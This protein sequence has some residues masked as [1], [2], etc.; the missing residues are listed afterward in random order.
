MLTRTLALTA[1]IALAG[2]GLPSGTRL[3]NAEEA[4]AEGY[5][6]AELRDLVG[7]I[8]LY[9][10]VV[11]AS[12]LP[13]TTYPADV[14]A[15]VALLAQQGGTVS[16]VPEGSTWDPSVQSLLQF[17]DVLTWL[18]Q[19]KEWVEQMAYAVAV[20]Q[21]AVLAAIQ[22]FRKEAQAAG[23][24][25]SD[26]HQVVSTEDTSDGSTEV[27]VIESSS[28][29]VVYVPT[30]Q[31][32][33]VVQ[34]AYTGWAWGAGFAMAAT[35]VWAYN[36]VNWGSNGGDININ[37]SINT[38]NINTGNINAGNN[39][40][41]NRATQFKAPASAAK[42]PAGGV[43]QPSQGGWG[44]ATGKPKGSG[45]KP[46]QR[47]GGA[48]T[49]PAARPGAAGPSNVGGGNK[50]SAGNPGGGAG[51]RPPTAK[52]AAGKPPARPSASP[53]HGFGGASD[54]AQARSQ[55]DRGASSLKQ[56]GGGAKGGGSYKGQSGR[57]SSG[58]G[59]R[60][61][62]GSSG[63]RSGGGGGGGRRR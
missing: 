61:G 41:P 55:S 31:P 47:P 33:A 35:G 39:V 20:Q 48:A 21:S 42:R 62:G 25:K 60:S 54:G 9:P 40:G 3:A 6:P 51:A 52:P 44:N 43:K 63:G 50:P 4:A 5:T 53:S 17:P 13:A 36:N 32:A 8:A 14:A 15:A 26:E 23:N 24:L 1:L 46:Q 34:P 28:P 7:P 27:I 58:G 19:N 37:N 38:G 16:A 57:S 10:D 45:V 29:T 11:I 56:S 49:K 59:S 12:I 30:Y 2:L 18:G 22:A